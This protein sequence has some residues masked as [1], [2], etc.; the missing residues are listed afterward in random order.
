MASGRVPKM[1]RIVGMS[2]W[3][4]KRRAMTRPGVYQILFRP[5]P[6]CFTK[7]KFLSRYEARKQ[8]ATGDSPPKFP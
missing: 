8:P 7:A 2:V 6:D 4:R 1:E 5:A 3:W